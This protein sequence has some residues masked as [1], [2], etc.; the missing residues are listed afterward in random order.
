[1]CIAAWRGA[2]PSELTQVGCM[3]FTGRAA[4]VDV[5]ELT[6]AGSRLSMSAQ[7]VRAGV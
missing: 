3:G 4:H 6:I 5:H 2:T 1:V 7:L